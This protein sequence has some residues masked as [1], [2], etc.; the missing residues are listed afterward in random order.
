M[1]IDDLQVVDAI[2]T[3]K[4]GSGVTLT[5][6]DHLEGGEAEHL[7]KLQEKLNT[8]LAFIESGEI[9]EAY[10]D[11]KGKNIHILAVFKHSPDN[12]GLEFIDN[13][14]KAI[15]NAGFGFK[16]EIYRT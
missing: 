11:S 12:T 6:T 2:G 13:C 16:Y 10:P 7:Y 15:E 9:Y 1:S 4:D 3:E 8:Y 14:R 5:I